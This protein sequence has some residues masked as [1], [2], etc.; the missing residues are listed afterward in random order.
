MGEPPKTAGLSVMPLESPII[1]QEDG[2][3]DPI[4]DNGK[5][6]VEKNLQIKSAAPLETDG[7]A[8]I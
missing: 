4:I 6:A 8:I 3:N 7:Y 1:S 5:A 2:A